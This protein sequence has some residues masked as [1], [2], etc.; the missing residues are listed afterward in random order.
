MT[1]F[2][3]RSGLIERKQKPQDFLHVSASSL[4]SKFLQ[5]NIAILPSEEAVVKI[6]AHPKCP[7]YKFAFA[8]ECELD[9]IWYYIAANGSLNPCTAA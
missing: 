4:I 5:D 8:G 2:L 1:H 3:R 6:S 7:F 9:R